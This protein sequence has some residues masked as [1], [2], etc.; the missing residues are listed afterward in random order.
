MR[1]AIWHLQLVLFVLPFANQLKLPSVQL[2]VSESVQKFC[3]IVVLCV[4]KATLHSAKIAAWIDQLN[5]TVVWR[6]CAGDYA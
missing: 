1:S 2:R 4:A 6:P 5:Y 3:E